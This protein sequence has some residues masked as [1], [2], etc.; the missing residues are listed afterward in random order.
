M[1][2]SSDLQGLMTMMPAFATDDAADPHATNTVSLDRLEKGLNRMI[3]DGANVIATTGSFGEF[4][5]LLPE[6]FE[7]LVRAAADI[8]NR[9]VPL[10][11]GATGLNTRE[12][13]RK[14]KVVAETKAAGVLIGVPFYFPSSPENAIRFFRDVA[15]AFPKLGI[16]IYHNP[17]LHNVKL[18]LG[19]MSEI[20][21]IPSVVAMKDSHR[22]P[23]E[24]M[25]LAEM[26]RGKMS[27]FV[28][29]LQYAAYGPLGAP[30]FWSIDAWMGPWPVLALRDAVKRGDARK[31]A[32][33]TLEIGPPVGANP[34][35]LSWRETAAK[36]AVRYA[37]YVDPGPLRAPFVEIPP[38]VDALQKRKSEKWKGLCE[39][40]RADARVPA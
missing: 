38:E 24:F 12:V 5:T 35:S 28:N 7:T 4:H 11:I 36:I 15:E 33:I 21:K 13:L 18:T 22:E 3:G 20:L 27:V 1:I 32:E 31:A 40:Y 10:F 9:R 2:A 14:L 25:R 29:Q 30:G 6:E 16:M 34:P 26:A 17:P 37:G 8:N 23:A 19:I 39:K